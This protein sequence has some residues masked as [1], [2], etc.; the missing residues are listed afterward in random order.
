MNSPS[1]QDVITLIR[2]L[3][4]RVKDFP[5]SN[6]TANA[7]PTANDDSDK[8]YSVGSW[9]FK[10]AEEKLWIC[11]DGAMGA[12]VWVEQGPPDPSGLPED[13]EG[14]LYNN[15]AG[16]L[17]WDSLVKWDPQSTPAYGFVSQFTNATQVPAFP[18]PFLTSGSEFSFNAATKDAVTH[19]FFYNYDSMAQP[20]TGLLAQVRIGDRFRCVA[21]AVPGGS[22]DFPRSWVVFEVTS[23]ATIAPF[24]GGGVV[25]DVG[26]K[27]VQRD[28]IN[29]VWANL[30]WVAVAFVPGGGYQSLLSGLVSYWPLDES[31]DIQH[32]VVGVNHLSDASFNAIRPGKMGFAQAF[33]FEATDVAKTNPTGMASRDWSIAG[34]FLQM[35]SNAWA[36]VSGS[37]MVEGGQ[38][39]EFPGGELTVLVGYSG[40]VIV[41]V[42]DAASIESEVASAAG[43]VIVGRWHFVAVTKRGTSL[44]LQIDNGTS[45]TG[46][47]PENGAALTQFSV[48]SGWGNQAVPSPA[49]DEIGFWNR[50]LTR[51]EI[52]TL[53]N[54][55]KGLTYPFAAPAMPGG[56]AGARIVSDGTELAATRSSE[57]RVVFD[58]FE[59]AALTGQFGAQ[60]WATAVGGAGAVT[61]IAGAQDA[62]GVIRLSA[63]V[64][65]ASA[66]IYSGGAARNSRLFGRFRMIFRARVRLNQVTNHSFSIGFQNAGGSNGAYFEFDTAARHWIAKTANG[67]ALTAIDSAWPPGADP[68]LWT[69]LE[70]DV[71]TDGREAKFIVDG[72]PQATSNTNIPTAAGHEFG[73]SAQTVWTVGSGG[74]VDV[75]WIEIVT[76]A[77][78]FSY[79]AMI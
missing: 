23:M 17:S 56:Y 2:Q 24:G 62:V 45:V 77:P 22:S 63:T 1:V 51:A 9:W 71:A 60:G 79:G 57:T 36:R 14:Y 25:Y 55:R 6:W 28:N 8:G 70:I 52:A 37:T 46:T 7:D 50:A 4:R 12:A 33:E 38:G 21:T 11:K 47:V 16:V 48:G 49:I 66:G 59:T 3:E 69:I 78:V 44:T 29:A 13:S 32:D 20:I 43:T 68:G 53:Y 5:R 64:A 54:Q 39:W 41:T 26:V 76:F 31:G 19:V 67:G 18:N 27:L 65:G 75:D 61:Q 40:Q 35:D 10:P 74:S 72:H 42:T 30:T 15:G 58:D 73:I 34:W